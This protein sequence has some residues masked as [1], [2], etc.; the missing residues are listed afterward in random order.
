MGV[1]VGGKGDGQGMEDAP[2]PHVCMI[3][4]ECRSNEGESYALHSRTWI[5][6]CMI[7]MA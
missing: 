7:P 2:L 4:D 5:V 6:R 3:I 1:W